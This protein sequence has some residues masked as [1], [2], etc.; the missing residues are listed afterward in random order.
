MTVTSVN[1]STFIAD[2]TILIRDALL[3]NITD[4]ISGTRASNER[5]VMT[6]Y[7][8]RPVKYPIITVK[9]TNI[10]M[11]KRLGMQ[12]EIHYTALPMEIRIWA[13]NEVEKDELTQNTIN[14]LRDL[15]YSASGTVVANLLGFKVTSAVN[16]DEPGDAGIK[17][18]VIGAQYN[19]ILG[20]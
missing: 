8:Q 13:R 2:T 1:T 9:N 16:V 10:D 5:F 14:Y 17:S 19:F 11:P 20:P 4:P 12:S 7:P 18:K 3:N 15:E 6:S